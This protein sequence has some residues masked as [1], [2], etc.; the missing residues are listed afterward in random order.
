MGCSK[1]STK[2]T[3]ENQTPMVNFKKDRFHL[4]N[5]MLQLKGL[6]KE[7]TKS[8]VRTKKKKKDWSINKEQKKINET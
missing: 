3:S 6:K 5:Q 4:K 7:L 2:K 1:N 8:E